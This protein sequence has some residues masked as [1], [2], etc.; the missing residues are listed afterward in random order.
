M[1]QLTQLDHS[2]LKAITRSP[3]QA[4]YVIRNMLSWKDDHWDCGFWPGLET[5]AVLRSCRRLQKC[6]LI[7]EASSSYAVMKCWEPAR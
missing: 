1:N 6:G 3:G 4:T 2:V 5:S 7:A